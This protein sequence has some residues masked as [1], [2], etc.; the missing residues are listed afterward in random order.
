M[1]PNEE[2][3]APKKFGATFGSALGLGC[4]PEKT[5]TPMGAP[6]DEALVIFTCK[7][8]AGARVAHVDGQGSR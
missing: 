8:G 5:V 7:G 1:V 6:F 2:G 4:V 3:R